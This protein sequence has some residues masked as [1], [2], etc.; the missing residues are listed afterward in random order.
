MPSSAASA[1][2]LR[3]FWAKVNVSS[4]MLIW[5]CLA[6]WRRPSTACRDR[7]TKSID[8]H[9]Q[10]HTHAP[11]SSSLRGVRN[12]PLHQWT[13]DDR[14]A[15]L[16]DA[17]GRSMSPQCRSPGL[18]TPVFPLRGFPLAGVRLR[19]RRPRCARRSSG[20]RADR[21]RSG[22]RANP[23]LLI[24][25]LR[26]HMRMPFAGHRPHHRAGVK[27]AAIDAHRAVEAAAD[28]E[29]GF[30]DPATFKSVLPI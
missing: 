9:W 4:V 13:L 27:L 26:R 17:G 28:F 25:E 16:F 22:R 14:R 7:R 8:R 18:K 24:V 3:G 2:M 23:Q 10:S 12:C 30:D 1:A 15:M 6:M 21:P 29:R 5:K 11:A 20:R 19:P